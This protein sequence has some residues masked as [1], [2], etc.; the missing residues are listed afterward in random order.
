M[1]QNTQDPSFR[2]V[3]SNPGH[4]TYCCVTLGKV[5]SFNFLSCKNEGVVNYSARLSWGQNEIQKMRHLA[6][7]ALRHHGLTSSLPSE[8]AGVLCRLRAVGG[9][10]K[11]ATWEQSLHAAIAEY[12]CLHVSQIRSR[13]FKLLK[14]I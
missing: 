12:I 3:S 8:T 11:T 7:Q 10:C 4:S 13:S 9:V 1:E 14:C 6:L 5:L 2:Q